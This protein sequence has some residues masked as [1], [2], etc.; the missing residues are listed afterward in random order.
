MGFMYRKCRCSPWKVYVWVLISS[1]FSGFNLWAQ[2]AYFIDGYHGGVYG[3]YPEWQTQFMIDELAKNPF[4]KINLEIEPE[5][6]DS[7]K[8]N[9]PE[10]YQNWKSALTD[11]EFADRIEFV[12]PASAQPYFFNISG[13]SAIRQ[14]EYGIKKT[15]EHFPSVTFSTY[16]SEEPCFTSALPQILK[17]F[18]FKYASLKNP[19]TC[20]GGY[21]RAHNGELVNWIGPDG[22]ALK[23]VPRY[24]VEDLVTESTWQTIAWNNSDQYLDACRASGMEHPIGM[25]LQDAAWD[26]GP[27]LGKKQGTEY[28]TWLNYFENVAT[29]EPKENWKFSQEDVLVSLMWGSQ[30]MQRLAQ[31]IRVAENKVVMAEKFAAFS[32]RYKPLKWPEAEFEEAWRT[33]SL[34]QHHDCWI[35]PYNGEKNNTWADKVVR[36][37]RTTN[38]ISHDVMQRALQNI[39][40]EKAASSDEKYIH[41]FNSTGAPR[42]EQVTINLPPNWAGADTEVQNERGEKVSAQL[43]SKPENGTKELVFLAEVPS[44][45]YTT[46]QLK[47]GKAFSKKGARVTKKK[48]NYLL[49]TDFYAMTVEPAKGGRIVSLIAKKLGNKEFVDKQNERSFNEIRGFFY[50]KDKFFSNVDQKADVRILE[51]G[52]LRVSVKIE[53]MIDEHPYTQVITL[54]QSD[55]KI[56]FD[57]TI[58]WKGNPGI[59]KYSQADN[60]KDEDPEKAF[61]NDKYKLL[62]LFPLNLKAQKL[63]KNAPFDVTESK[64]ENTFFNRWDSIKHNVIVNWVDVTDGKADHGLALFTDHTTSYAHG[65]E[66]PL[67]LNLQYSGKGLWGRDYKIAGPSTIRYALVPHSNTWNEAAL[68]TESVNWNEPLMATVKDRSFGNQAKKSLLAIPGGGLE[69]TTMKYDENGLMVRLFNAEAAGEVQKLV[70]DGNV[71]RAELIELDGRVA[72]GLEISRAENKSTVV[73]PIPQFGVRTLRLSFSE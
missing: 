62:A 63:Y 38:D 15:N 49:E 20:W 64:L 7:V 22:T 10:A 46:Y 30:V 40:T 31:Q 29:Q 26:N 71:R 19:N 57:L 27:W 58:D 1:L 68:W 51:N 44:L 17:S 6:W 11:P 60:Y 23:T 67:A 56:D 42:T 50:E 39:P 13:E 25:C 3:H 2:K 9:D 37:T 55:R 53:G 72:G 52:P 35:V 8:V 4:W 14:L 66:H 33:L 48:D 70:F 24:A 73:L 32:A 21:T 61:Y 43:I 5:T 28:T 69:V 54:R 45:G 47:K 12:N 16:S 34:A 36:W 65:K 59:G 41:I 18:G